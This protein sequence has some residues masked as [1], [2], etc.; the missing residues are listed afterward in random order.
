MTRSR[1]LGAATAS[2][3]AASSLFAAALFAPASAYDDGDGPA[4]EQVTMTDSEQSAPEVEPGRYRLQLPDAT[5][6]SAFFT[7]PRTE[8]GSTIWVGESTFAD[9]PTD[10]TYYLFPT[11]PETGTDCGD[12]VSVESYIRLHDL[13]AGSVRSGQN[14]RKA[15]RVAFRHQSAD[16]AKF[17]NAATTLVVWEEPPV[18][19]ASI[20]PPPSITQKW[21]GAEPPSKGTVELGSTFEDAPELVEGRWQVH[22][23]PGRAA[24]FKVPLDWGQ[25]MELALTFEGET[26]PKSVRVEPILINPVGGFSDWGEAVDSKKADAPH[27]QDIDLAYDL[28]GGVVSPSITWRNREKDGVTAAFPGD[29]YVLLRLAKQDVRKQGADIIISNTVIT[30]KDAASP[31]ASS[32]DPIPALDGSDK[33]SDEGDEKKE[34]ASDSS[35]DKTPWP[36]VGGLFGGSALAAVA[37]F[38]ALAKHRRSRA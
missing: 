26:T 33:A 6:S 15:D 13:V 29:Y 27:F 21:T 7:V 16:A 9:K 37:G 4:D 19:D 18:T 25:H 14:C 1:R 31:Y 28:D 32:A 8:K 22:V 38:V 3:F 36:A 5:M 17:G 10:D 35:A 24:L 2:G 11:D 30:D 34:S 12:A 23:D 20:L